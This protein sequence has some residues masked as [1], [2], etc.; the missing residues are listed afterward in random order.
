MIAIQKKRPGIYIRLDDEM[1]GILDEMSRNE[2]ISRQ[3]IIRRMIMKE[4]TG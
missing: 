3:A 2:Q 4:R 1:M